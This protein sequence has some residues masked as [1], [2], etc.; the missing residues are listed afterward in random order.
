YALNHVL[1]MQVLGSLS[2]DLILMLAVALAMVVH[3]LRYRSQVVNGMAFLLAYFPVALS[4]D[5]VY[6]L[7][8]GVILAVGL[9]AIVIK[10]GWFELEVFGVLSSYGNH[11]YWLY[12][13]LG[14]HGAQGR[15]FEAYHASLALLL[16]Y[17]LIFRISYAVFCLKKKKK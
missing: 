3:T 12:R 16:F 11:L 6:S 5:D 7:S 17:W 10:M 15:H 9:V 1:A 4:N 8:A 2:A 14:I 13:I